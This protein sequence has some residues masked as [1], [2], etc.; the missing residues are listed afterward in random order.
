[1]TCERVTRVADAPQTCL[2]LKNQL[3]A[4]EPLLGA[5]KPACDADGTYSAVQ[6]HGSVCYCADKLGNKIQHYSDNISKSASMNCKCARDQDAYMKTGLI[7]KMFYCTPSG[8]Y[9]NY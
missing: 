5:F 1:M 8:N 7:G 3:E 9:Q 2:E 4:S 6:C